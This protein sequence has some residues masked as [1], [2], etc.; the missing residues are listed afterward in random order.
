MSDK[1]DSAFLNLCTVLGIQLP[2]GYSY[3]DVMMLATLRIRRL[4]TLEGLDWTV[5]TGETLP[6]KNGDLILVASRIGGVVSASAE[7]VRAV[8]NEQH[9][10]GELCEFSHWKKMP[11]HPQIPRKIAHIH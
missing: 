5:M 9:A 8:W 11:S 3:A 2:D 7:Y 1:L 6:E 4:Q 10:R